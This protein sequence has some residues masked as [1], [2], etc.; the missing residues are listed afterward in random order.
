MQN[1]PLKLRLIDCGS[2]K[3]PQIAEMVRGDVS[4]LE[5][6]PLARANQSDWQGL[7]ALIISGGP[8]LFSDPDQAPE[9]HRQFR[10]INQ[11]RMPVLGICL[12]HQALGLAHGASIFRGEACRQTIPIELLK[13]H[14]LLQGL[15]N[16]SSFGED[17]TEGIDLPPGYTHL[18]RSDY[19]QVE[20]MANDEQMRYGVQ[21]HPEISGRPGLALF[22]NFLAIAAEAR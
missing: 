21:F 6:I 17:H 5:I 1:N 18:G 7:N 16:P 14:P 4:S 12:G 11:L 8:S 13:E 15:S 9:L 19:Y 10:F 20:I 22:R 2:S 3:V